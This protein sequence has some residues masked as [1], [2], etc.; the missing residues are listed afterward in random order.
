MTS[1]GWSVSDLNDFIGEWAM[2]NVV[3]DYKATPDTFRSTYGNITL[4]DKA[5]RLHRL[6]PLEALDTSWASNRRFAS[7]FYGAPQ[8]FGYNVVRLYPTNGASTVLRSITVALWS[9]SSD[10]VV[11]AAAVTLSSDSVTPSLNVQKSP[12][13]PPELPEK[14]SPSEFLAVCLPIQTQYL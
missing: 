9:N 1:R 11:P 14:R 3:W 13:C 10:G 5:E 7:P 8:R 4:T 6:M 2:H 12:A